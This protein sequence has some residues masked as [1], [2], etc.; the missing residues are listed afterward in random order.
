MIFVQDPNT[1]EGHYMPV[2]NIHISIDTGETLTGAMLLDKDG[3][4]TEILYDA[5]TIL[6]RNKE[7]EWYEVEVDTQLYEKPTIH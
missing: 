4:P 3:N 1:P 5:K 6:A 7:L 2:E